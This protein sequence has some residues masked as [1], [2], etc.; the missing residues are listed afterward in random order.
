MVDASGYSGGRMKFAYSF[1][2]LSAL[3]T[4]AALTMLLGG[5]SPS[6]T[7]AQDAIRKSPVQRGSID[8]MVSATGSVFPEERSSLSFEQPGYV[9]EI[10]VVVGS[11]VKAGDVLA[12]VDSDILD[13]SVAQAELRLKSAQVAYNQLYDP[14]SKAQIAGAQAAVAGAV[15]AYNKVTAPPDPEQV[16]V[17]QLQYEQAYQAYLKDPNDGVAVA[18]LESAR[19]QLKLLTDPP[20]KNAVAAASAA[21]SQAQATLDGMRNGPSEATIARAQN[22]IDQAQLALDR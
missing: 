18:N 9:T 12:R 19:L 22:Q 7:A 3:I 16:R 1:G 21:I 2:R 14:P 4:L 11:Q 20:D 15:A 6:G 17:A 5:C 13:V 8:Q 10:N